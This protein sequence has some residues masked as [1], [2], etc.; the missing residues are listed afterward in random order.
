[1][2]IKADALAAGT[3][4]ILSNLPALKENFHSA[5]VFV[6]PKDVEGF[7]Q[8]ILT[9]LSDPEKCKKLKKRT[10]TSQTI[11]L[12]SSRKART[13][14]SKRCGQALVHLALTYTHF[15]RS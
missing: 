1:M 4:C 13:R 5:A 2:I 12:G 15:A 11:F 14:S 9:L 8:A 3:P 6:D 7:A 10:K